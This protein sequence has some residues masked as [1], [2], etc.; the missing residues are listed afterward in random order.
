MG[1]SPRSAKGNIIYHAI[2]R[3][4]GRM[5]IF[6]KDADYE[7]FERVIEEAKEKFPIR[8]YAYTIMPNHWHFILHPYQDE[9]LSDF[10]RWLTLTHTQRWNTCH[11][12][13]GY[14]HLYQGRFKS[15]P[16]QED[17]YFIQLCRYIERNPLRAGL[18]Q[19]VQDWRWSSLWRRLYGSEKQKRLLDLWPIPE[20]EDYLNLINQTEAD[21]VIID[22]RESIQ[23][24]KP[25]GEGSWI[26]KIV[27]FLGL[28]S[29]IKPRG[30]P[31]KGT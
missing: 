11:H 18:V 4:N 19:R 21:A 22:I 3:A 17:A 8:I 28:E 2:N 7:A 31:K 25:F 20:K 30:R 29:T 13:I 26:G 10:L 27:K 5:T 12:R 9:D 24:G 15:F 14:R 16:V 6:E 23:R 1:R